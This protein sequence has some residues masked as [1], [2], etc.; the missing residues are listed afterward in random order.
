MAINK[1]FDVCLDKEKKKM[2]LNTID[3]YISKMVK[4]QSSKKEL[5]R[6]RWLRDEIDKVSVCH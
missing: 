6:Y 4:V 1:L 2:V 5:Q 3:N